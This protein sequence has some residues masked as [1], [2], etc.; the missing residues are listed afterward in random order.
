MSAVDSRLM[1][2]TIKWGNFG[3]RGNFGSG[4]LVVKIYFWKTVQIYN[5]S[6]IFSQVG[7]TLLRNY[8]N[9]YIWKK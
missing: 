1:N 5:D 7:V 6:N 2:C 8:Q 3:Y 9:Y 4:I